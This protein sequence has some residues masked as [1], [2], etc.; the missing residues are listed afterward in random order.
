MIHSF[1]TFYLIDLIFELKIEF[2]FTLKCNECSEIAHIH[3]RKIRFM[4]IIG[5]GSLVMMPLVGNLS[6]KY[7]RKALLTVPMT[8]TIIPLGMQIAKLYLI[9]IK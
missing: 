3:K 1:F 9:S 8:L 2:I 4:Q 5:L 6:D 7:G